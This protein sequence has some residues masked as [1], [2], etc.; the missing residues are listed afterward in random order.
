MATE[1]MPTTPAT[2][3]TRPRKPLPIGRILGWSVLILIIFVT[4][5]PFWWI[6]RTALSTQRE[7][8]ANPHSLL[9]VGFTA[10]NFQRV[11][12]QISAADAI[13]LGGSGQVLNFPLYLRNSIIVSVMVV[14]GQIFFSA[15]A[16]YAFARMRFP[17]REQIFFCYIAALLIPS[18]VTLI[19]NF[20]LIRSLHLE[21]TFWGIVAPTILM[22]PFAV[23]FLR[24]FFLGINRELEEAAKLDGASIFGCFWRIVVPLSWPPI[25]TLA[26]LTFV[27]TWNN[28]LWPFLVGQNENVRVLTVALAVFRSQTPQGAPD[29]TGLMAGTVVSIV[30]TVLLFLILGRRVINSIQFSGIK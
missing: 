5:F 2:T 6:I 25:T 30:P 26:I 3:V 7:L 24:Q 13:K 4:L 17:F 16:A 1:T 14:V 18:I 11:L 15:L 19:P 21:N 23:F 9:P 12:G 8:I 28:Y 20:I 10:V 22:S 27:A 29:W